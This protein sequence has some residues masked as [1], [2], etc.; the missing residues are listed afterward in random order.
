MLVAPT[1]TTKQ[2]KR[3]AEDYSFYSYSCLYCNHDNKTL[4]TTL[5]QKGQHFPFM[6]THQIFITSDCMRKIAGE[7]RVPNRVFREFTKASTSTTLMQSYTIRTRMLKPTR[8]WRCSCWGVV[9]ALIHIVII[10]TMWFFSFLLFIYLF[11]GS[12]HVILS[13]NCLL[14]WFLFYVIVFFS[15]LC[16]PTGVEADLYG[17]FLYLLYVCFC[18]LFTYM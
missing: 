16:S 2:I 8:S 14:V 1:T 10:Y 15:S 11:L 17:V 6:D 12:W 5:T 13:S 3:E 4:Y 9:C 18:I 7:N